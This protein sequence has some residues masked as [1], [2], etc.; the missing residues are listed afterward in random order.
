SPSE[1]NGY[2][3]FVMNFGDSPD[4]DDPVANGTTLSWMTWATA[5]G[6]TPNTMYHVY[7]QSSCNGGEQSDYA[8]PF[9]ITTTGGGGECTQPSDIT[10]STVTDAVVFVSWTEN[11]DATQWEIEYGESGFI[12]GEGTI[13]FD[14]DGSPNET[15]GGL[16]Q[17]VEYDVYVRAVCDFSESEWTGPVSFIIEPEPC[18]LPTNVVVDVITPSMVYVTWTESGGATQWEIEYGE[19]GFIQGE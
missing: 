9:M 19:T 4:M 12:Q 2:N 3:W 5:T 17:G 8:G 14:N 10:I 18:S 15:I 6:L 11:G 13:I 1:V 16:T 7:L